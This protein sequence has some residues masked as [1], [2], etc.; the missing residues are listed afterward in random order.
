MC[1]INKPL[2]INPE[3]AEALFLVANYYKTI[4]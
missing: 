3:D 2:E 1:I 4:V